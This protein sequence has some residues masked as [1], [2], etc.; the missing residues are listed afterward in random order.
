MG[1]YF[2]PSKGAESW[3]ELLADPDK[4]W[5]ASYSAYELAFCWEA[6]DNLPACV[7]SVFKKSYIP[8]FQNV[9]VLYGFPEYKVALPGGGAQSQNDLYLLAK[10]D[11]NLLTIM[12]EGKVSETFGETLITWKG[13]TPSEG[14]RKRLKYLLELLELSEEE[15][16]HT[17][18]QL[19]HR[20]AS[21]VKEAKEVNA[22]NA[23][24]LVHS[25]SKE[26]KWFDDYAQFVQLFNLEA[27]KDVVVGPVIVNGVN[28][29][30]AWVT[31]E[32]LIAK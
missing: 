30:F 6:A 27:S 23:L 26:G 1:K 13:E 7:E 10:A 16:L 21:A 31:G 17:R 12:V 3:R 2:L 32:N 18:Y 9:Q 15:A 14:K 11:G 22:K 28:L 20:T 24:M 19:L 5:K 25:F 29:Y 8:L 4:H